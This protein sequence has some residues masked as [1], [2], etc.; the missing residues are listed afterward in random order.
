MMDV[1][2]FARCAWT[3]LLIPLPTN[4]TKEQIMTAEV[5]TLRISNQKMGMQ[6]HASILK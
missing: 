6:E 1:T 2:F 3:G 4:A 5:A